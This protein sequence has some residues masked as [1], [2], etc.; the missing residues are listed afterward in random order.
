[1]K[2]KHMSVCKCLCT[3][4]HLQ[5]GATS[6]TLGQLGKACACTCA[7]IHLAH[8]AES[9]REGMLGIAPSEA[10]LPEAPVLT[11]LLLQTGKKQQMQ[12]ASS[13]ML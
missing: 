12:D 11:G 1:M 8:P 7:H 5:R 3:L 10:L 4:A 13:I 2:V 9:A 6:N